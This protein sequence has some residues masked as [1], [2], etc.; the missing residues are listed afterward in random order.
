MNKLASSFDQIKESGGLGKA[1]AL[2]VAI[3]VVKYAG[4]AVAFYGVARG[5][6]PA[7]AELPLW[8]VL[9]GLMSGEGG[10]ALPIPTVMSLGTYEA[11]GA[12]ALGLTGVSGAEAALVLLGTHVASQIVDYTL[13]GL[14]L[15]G[16][17]W[18]GRRT[19]AKTP[20]TE[21]S[22]GRT[23][24]ILLT[25]LTLLLLVVVCSATWVWRVNQKAGA[26]E[27]PGPGAIIEMGLTEMSA[28][29]DVWGDHKGFIVWSST[30]YGEH[31]L[32]RMEWPSGQMKRLTRG[33]FVDN[34]P[35]ISPE[36]KRVVFARSR[37]AWVSFR[38][39]EEWDIWILYLSNGKERLLAERGAEPSWTGDGKAVVFQR[40]GREVVQVDVESGAET[41]LLGARPGAI[42]TGPV[43]D[44]SG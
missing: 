21:S 24:P 6:S 29:D 7:L 1:A 8:Q 42:W 30:M 31:D 5:L 33:P 22:A 32:V 38:N 4:L 27:A 39:L 14:G 16:L 34:T 3:R 35:K 10:A 41:V 11:A 9:I 28:L 2:S 37:Q 36:G 44:P 17:L 20:P 23:N 43:V 15:L 25:W 40:G 13:G 19:M 26:R 12:G 18:A